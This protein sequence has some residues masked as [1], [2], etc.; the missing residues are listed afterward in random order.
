MGGHMHEA[1]QDEEIAQGDER[2]KMLSESKREMVNY[3]SRKK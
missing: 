3:L 2:R 1:L